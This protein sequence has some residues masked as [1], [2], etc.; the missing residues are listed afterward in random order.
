MAVRSYVGREL[1]WVTPLYEL[2]A[3]GLS[4]AR[5]LQDGVSIEVLRL[6]IDV[7]R[8]SL[9]C[10]PKG[11]LTRQVAPGMMIAEQN[12]AKG[13]RLQKTGEIPKQLKSH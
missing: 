10:D 3:L 5:V 2:S 4:Y 1:T 9:A 13:Q 8:S 6:G 7:D 11:G 12:K